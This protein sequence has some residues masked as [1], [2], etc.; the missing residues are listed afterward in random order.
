[1]S[2][3]FT[4]CKAFFGFVPKT[5]SSDTYF[6]G[7]LSTQPRRHRRIVITRD[8]NP[9]ISAGKLG[10]SRRIAFMHSVAGPEIVETVAA[11]TKLTD[12]GSSQ[13]IRSQWRGRIERSFSARGERCG[14]PFGKAARA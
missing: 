8:P 5:Q 11:I 6:V 12:A 7:D 4:H 14:E 3:H 9:F 2:R 1:M 13:S 10:Q